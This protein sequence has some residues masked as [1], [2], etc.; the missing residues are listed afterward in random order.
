MSLTASDPRQGF[1]PIFTDLEVLVS[2]Q[3]WNQEQLR[4]QTRR[5]KPRRIVAQPSA[6]VDVLDLPL[7]RVRRRDDLLVGDPFADDVSDTHHDAEEPS[8]EPFQW[9]RESELELHYVLL[10]RSLQYLDAR[11]NRREKEDILQWIFHP[12]TPESLLKQIDGKWERIL[13]PFTFGTCCRLQGVDPEEMRDQIR[14]K[15]KQSGLT[16]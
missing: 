5:H 3:V 9:A 16:F 2:H 4:R 7:F 8:L 11:G 6:A 10:N 15:C 13:V 14:A 12:E 1:L